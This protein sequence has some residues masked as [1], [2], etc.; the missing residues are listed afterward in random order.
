MKKNREETAIEL[1]I[2][3]TEE[4]VEE[5]TLVGEETRTKDTVLLRVRLLPDVQRLKVRKLDV[6][7]INHLPMVSVCSRVNSSFFLQMEIHPTSLPS[8]LSL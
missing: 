4:I 3:R 8:R 5:A 7:S 1:E 2:P 6:P